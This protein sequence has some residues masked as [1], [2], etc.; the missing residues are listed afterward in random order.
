MRKIALLFLLTLAVPAYADYAEI[1]TCQEIQ[2]SVSGD[3]VTTGEVDCTGVNLLV[4]AVSSYEGAAAC[5]LSDSE[6]N[7]WTGLTQQTTSGGNRIR[8]FY[9]FAPMVSAMQTFTCDGAGSFPGIIAKGWSGADTSPFDQQNGTPA[10]G[11]TATLATGPITPTTN[12]QLIVSASGIDFNA[13]TFTSAS[14]LTIAASAAH[15][16][17]S[18]AVALAWAVQTS[19]TAI[20]ST[21]TLSGAA[22]LWSAVIASFKAAAASGPPIGS[23]M[24]T[25]VGR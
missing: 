6:A 10:P 8:L 25:G 4:V 7:S 21:W 19:A 11:S 5:T 1:A 23:M 3:G 16:G 12:N 22:S 18:E 20:N 13:A 9:V 15:T 14:D 17:S 24:L 2:Q